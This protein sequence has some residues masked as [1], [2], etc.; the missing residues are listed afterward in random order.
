MAARVG[1]SILYSSVDVAHGECCWAPGAYT[2]ALL[3]RRMG[4]AR[5]DIA[6]TIY[7]ME[8][9]RR[10]VRW[11]GFGSTIHEDR[12]IETNFYLLLQ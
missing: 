6:R 2:T 11:S 9:M 4:E 5:I 10:L 7:L 8:G 12:G 1:R 3:M